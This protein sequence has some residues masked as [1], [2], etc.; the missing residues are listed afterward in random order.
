VEEDNQTYK[1]VSKDL[2]QFLSIVDG[3][4]FTNREVDEQFQYRT[5]DAKRYRWQILEYHVK[6]GELKRVKTGVYRKPDDSFEEMDIL[7]AKEGDAIPLKMPLELHKYIRIYRG[8]VVV[9]AGSPG[10]GKTG[11]MYELIMLNAPHPAGIVLWTNDMTDVE[12]KERLLNYQ[13]PLPNPL[14][15]KAYERDSNFGDVVAKFPDS[16]NIIDYL[17]LN[18]ETYLIGAEIES[19]H[20]ALGKG[21]AVIGIQKRPNQDIGIG[22]LFSWKRPKYY[23]AIDVEESITGLTRKLKIVKCRGRVNP[24]VNPHGKIFRYDLV[25][26]VKCRLRD[27]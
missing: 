16:I 20:R 27:G 11:F 9:V 4:S 22:G 21:I 8:S 25:G 23:F 7:G 17:D 13:N 18:S 10:A 3:S 1:E 2:D 15:F 19:I 14:P 12:T 5:R 24:M 6:N 26:G